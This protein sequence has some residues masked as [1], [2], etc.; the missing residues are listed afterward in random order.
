MSARATAI[1]SLHERAPLRP[2]HLARLRLLQHDGAGTSLYVATYPLAST[3]VR[4]ELPPEPMP[5]EQWCRRSETAEAMIG[6]FFIRAEGKPL[7]ELRTHGVR[8]PS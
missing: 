8:R 2:R 1:R 7:G 4:V 5:L 6:G 3:E